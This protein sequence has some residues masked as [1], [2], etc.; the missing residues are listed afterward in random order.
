MSCVCRSKEIEKREEGRR[1]E[2]G[3]KEGEKRE[4]GRREGRGK[5]RGEGKADRGHSPVSK[6][7]AAPTENFP[8]AAGS[9]PQR[10]ST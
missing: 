7:E 2:G 5:F 10:K 9:R 4:E 3:R 6:G 8:Q 1:E